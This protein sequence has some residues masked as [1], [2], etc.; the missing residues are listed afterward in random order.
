MTVCARIINKK[1]RQSKCV[2]EKPGGPL[3]PG[4]PW[5]PLGPGIGSPISTIG[6]LGP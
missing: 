1:I 5:K 6:P 4:S 2:P 3:L